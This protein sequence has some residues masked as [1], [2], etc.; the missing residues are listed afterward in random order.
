LLAACSITLDNYCCAAGH[1]SV[2]AYFDGPVHAHFLERDYV[3]KACG[4]ALR[5]FYG[6]GLDCW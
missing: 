1:C 6:T 5:V 2:P 3:P 4:L